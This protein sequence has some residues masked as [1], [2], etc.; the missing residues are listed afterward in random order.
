[1]NGKKIGKACLFP[2]LAVAI[3]LVPIATVLLIYAMVFVGTETVLAYISYAL[4]VYTLTVWCVRVP[5][6]VRRVKRFRQENAY[7][8]RWSEDVRLRVNVSLFGSFLWN[9][10][11]AAFQLW[12]GIRNASFWFYSLAVYYLFLAVMRFFLGRHAGKYRAGEHMRAEWVRY[13]ACGWCFLLMNL[14]LGVMIFFMLYFNRTFEHGEIVTISM[15][16]YTFFT[17]AKAIINLVRYRKYDSPVYSASKI[18]GLAAACVSM[19]TLTSTMLNT[20]SD[21]SLTSTGQKLIL[22]LTGVGVCAF[23]I[24]MAIYMIYRATTKLKSEGNQDGR[25]TSESRSNDE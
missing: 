5:R 11:Y 10:V 9:A 8:R 19:L 25:Q 2:P 15:A 4:A 16:A 7:A 1:M 13:R 6:I 3:A 14:A 21:A 24:A 12:L 23:V 18:V 20:F 22:G 17:F